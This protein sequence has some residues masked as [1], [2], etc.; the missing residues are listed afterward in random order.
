MAYGAC[1]DCGCS[2]EQC[3]CPER[4]ESMTTTAHGTYIHDYQCFEI[5]EKLGLREA[6]DLLKSAD[7]V[8]PKTYPGDDDFKN[9]SGLFNKA[10]AIVAIDRDLG[11]VKAVYNHDGR[12]SLHQASIPSFLKRIENARSWNPDFQKLYDELTTPHEHA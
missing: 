5:V 12:Y 8:K 11:L 6:F 4:E 3:E 1:N 10:W 2:Y 7:L 9:R